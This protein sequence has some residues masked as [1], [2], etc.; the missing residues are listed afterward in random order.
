MDQNNYGISEQRPEDSASL[1]D[2]LYTVTAV[3]VLVNVVIFLQTDF[4]SLTGHENIWIERGALSWHSVFLEHEYYRML[5]SM[6]LHRDIEHISNNML[7]LFFFGIYMEQQLG[8]IRY[9]ILY[10]CSG[11]LA[12]CT[13]MV[14][15]M[16]QNDYITSIGASGAIFG[17]MGGY[18]TL[19][20]LRRR[21]NGISWNQ[22][23][24][25]I[26]LSIYSGVAT[27]GVDNAAHIGGLAAG[28]LIA[29]IF[30]FTE[31]GDIHAA[32]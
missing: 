23:I 4:T 32:N 25:A 1:R 11:L 8:K 3:L 12:G 9:L 2:Y 13:S 30:N 27:Q 28:I 6:F 5:T 14:Y 18:F 20:V 24:F 21:E 10:F 17:V 7:I 26:F 29:L 19:L 31:M 16:M 15:N 22:L